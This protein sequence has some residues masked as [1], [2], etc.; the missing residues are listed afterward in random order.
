MTVLARVR[1]TD[2]S[3]T[4][5]RVAHVDVVQAGHT[6]ARSSRVGSVHELVKD[7]PPGRGQGCPRGPLSGSLGRDGSLLSLLRLPG[8]APFHPAPLGNNALSTP[9]TP[10]LRAQTPGTIIALAG[11][12]PPL[13]IV[14]NVVVDV[15]PVSNPR[16]VRGKVGER[17]PV[18]GLVPPIVG[19]ALPLVTR[20][21]VAAELVR[22][23]AHNQLLR[24]CPREGK[25]Y[26]T[27]YARARGQADNTT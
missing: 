5:S 16:G 12:V 26:F 10:R 24:L 23:V 22:P 14:E 17:E 27:A 1:R 20:R 2:C 21:I 13:P 15:G 18:L 11:V 19:S 6:R 3:P 8:P 9:R 4:D 25:G 7:D